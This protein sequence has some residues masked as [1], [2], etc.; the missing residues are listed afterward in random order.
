MRLNGFGK[1]Q[2]HATRAQYVVLGARGERP[3]DIGIEKV[4]CGSRDL[5]D[6]EPSKPVKYKTTYYLNKRL[7]TSMKQVYSNSRLGLEQCCFIELRDI[8]T[9]K[10]GQNR[11][12]KKRTIV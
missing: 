3:L 12:T 5:G 2:L 6:E 4:N 7:P 8:L 9:Y 11:P 10:N 1:L